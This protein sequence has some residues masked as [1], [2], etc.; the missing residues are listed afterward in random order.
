MKEE[1]RERMFS[2]EVSNV[3]F[4]SLWSSIVR[5]CTLH[6]VSDRLSWDNWHTWLERTW[7]VVDGGWWMRDDGEIEALVY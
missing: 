6:S 4:G 5:I 3:P 1:T 2:C 7:L